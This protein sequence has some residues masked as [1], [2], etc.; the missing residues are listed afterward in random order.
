MKKIQARELAPLTPGEI[1]SLIKGGVQ[2]IDANKDDIKMVFDK[3]A[4]FFRSIGGPNSPGG[5]LKRIEALE[6][7]DRLQKELNKIN[8]AEF[9]AL[10]ARL[11][12]LEQK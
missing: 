10:R 8:D 5:R 3:I 11:L 6:A 7:K 9:T 2:F 12:A 1:I 4:D